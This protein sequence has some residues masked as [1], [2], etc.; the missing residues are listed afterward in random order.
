MPTDAITP[1]QTGRSGAGQTVPANSDFTL[2]RPP[3]QGKA[4]P[5]DGEGLPLGSDRKND[6]GRQQEIR[7][8]VEKLREYAS[9][10]GRRLEFRIDDESGR[11]VIEVKDPETGDI[12]RQ[13][14]GD[15]VLERART[16]PD[17]LNL[18]D[19]KA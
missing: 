18:F 3:A 19:E 11:T 2:D 14:P 13:I 5:S 9:G 4:V 8:A 10:M 16:N 1:A 15:D 12:L 17:S 7:Q 6:E